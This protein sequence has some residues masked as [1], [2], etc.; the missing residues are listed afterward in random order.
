MDQP[1][2]SA[3]KI[4]RPRR[5][6]NA[7]QAAER[8]GY[9][10]SRFRILTRSGVLPSPIHLGLRKVMWDADVLERYIADRAALSND[11]GVQ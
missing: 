6:L 4:N 2:S 9:S 1:S 5:L 8:T 7:R 11:G 10:E 3:E